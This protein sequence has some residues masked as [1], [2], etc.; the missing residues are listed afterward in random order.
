GGAALGRGGRAPARREGRAGRHGVELLLGVGLVS[1]RV[2]PVER[3][4]RHQ[5]VVEDLLVVAANHHE[6]V[7]GGGLPPPAELG[8]GGT[9]GRVPGLPDLKGALAAEVA[10]AGGA[11]AVEV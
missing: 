10:A 1:Y 3:E 6:A 8:D 5:L 9:A 11:Q 7:E 2:T 4:L